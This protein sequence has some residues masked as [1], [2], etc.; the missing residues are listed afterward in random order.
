LQKSN[1][2]EKNMIEN[3]LNLFPRSLIKFHPIKEWK[4]TKWDSIEKQAYQIFEEGDN[5]PEHIEIINNNNPAYLIS[6][7]RYDF[8][9]ILIRLRQVYIDDNLIERNILKAPPTGCPFFESLLLCLCC[10]EA[11]GQFKYNT[12]KHKPLLKVLEND[13]PNY[14]MHAE[15]I[16]KYFRNGLAHTLRPY[17]KFHVNF[18][19]KTLYRPPHIFKIKH[20]NVLRINIPHFI[21]TLIIALEKYVNDLK[22]YNSKN[23]MVSYKRYLR[24][25]KKKINSLIEKGINV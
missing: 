7:I 14:E 5:S 10:T 16:E 13:L 25:R 3:K 22:S 6:Y 11:M 18:N 15:I 9:K 2:L 4:K 20:T 12:N 23:L 1:E 17:G 19:T 21:D 8:K 24:K